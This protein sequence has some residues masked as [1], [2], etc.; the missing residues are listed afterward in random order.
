MLQAKSFTPTEQNFPAYINNNKCL[1]YTWDSTDN[2]GNPA[3]GKNVVWWN[4]Y[5]RDRVKLILEN[6]IP[7]VMVSPNA[8]Y[9]EG[10][11]FVEYAHGADTNAWPQDCELPYSKTV[12]A[13]HMTELN[14]TARTLVGNRLTSQSLNDLLNSNAEAILRY[15][16]AGIGVGKPNVLLPS[17]AGVF[18]PNNQQLRAAT[19][20]TD[21]RLPL[22]LSPHI[23][24]LRILFVS[25]ANAR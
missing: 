18:H 3:S 9:V 17:S 22:W 2:L 5:I 19:L 8:Q 7:Q 10:F 21:C 11:W 13:E 16:P 6:V 15:I 23:R 20:H 14:S 1:W 25:T 4:P 24:Q 12:Y